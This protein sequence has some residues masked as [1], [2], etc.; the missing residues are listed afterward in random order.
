[1]K[2]IVSYRKGQFTDYVGNVHHF[3]VAA[4]STTEPCD[5]DS[6]LYLTEYD[7]AYGDI[8]DEEPINKALLIGI[9]I[10]N[11]RDEFDEEKGKKIAYNKAVNGK[12]LHRPA[13]YT[14]RPGY[15]NTAVVEAVL[16][17]IVNYIGKDPGS[18]I[19]G[20]NDAE[21]KHAKKIEDELFVQNSSEEL[22]N[23]AEQIKFLS[24]EDRKK[25]DKL[26]DLL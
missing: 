9:A 12:S 10:C 6:D 14:T 5:P 22:L 15:I 25:L 4:V 8:I 23:I 3:V 19:P 13:I 7:N 21:K 1:M 2:E 24:T 11:P 17:N 20:Y 16:D 18:V 26:V